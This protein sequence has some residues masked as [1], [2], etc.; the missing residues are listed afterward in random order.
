MAVF[1]K[2]KDKDKGLSDE[3]VKKMH[4]TF[5]NLSIP[6]RREALAGLKLGNIHK[7][8]L[9]QLERRTGLSYQTIANDLKS[10]EYKDIERQFIEDFIQETLTVCYRDIGVYIRAKDTPTRERIDIE[11]WFINTHRDKVL[12][13]KADS[14]L[15]GLLMKFLGHDEEKEEIP[16]KTTPD[17]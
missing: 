5:K 1:G 9:R 11:K 16:E 3:D 6:A 10:D 17:S 13:L 7:L 4:E 8:S 15:P 14:G 12:Q 2:K